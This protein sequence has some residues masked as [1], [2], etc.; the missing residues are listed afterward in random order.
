VAVLELAIQR[1]HQA[2]D[3][4]VVALTQLV[5]LVVLA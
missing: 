5:I 2:A 3:Q 1:E 4:A